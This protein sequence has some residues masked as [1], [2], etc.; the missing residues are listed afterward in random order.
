MR[1]LPILRR[2]DSNV[3]LTLN[4]ETDTRTAMVR[5][6]CEYLE[7]MEFSYFGERV[8]RFKKVFE[9]WSEFEENAEYP[10]AFV[11]EQVEGE[12]DNEGKLTPSVEL[13]DMDSPHGLYLVCY[14][15]YTQSL[16]IQLWATDPV[17]RMALVAMIENHLNPVEWKTGVSVVLPHYFNAVCT[18]ELRYCKYE[19]SKEQSMQ[20]YR[21]ASIG[22]DARVPLLRLGGYPTARILSDV[23]VD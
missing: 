2:E 21:V 5:G 20:R 17:E 7:D 1:T 18:F 9:S 6:L 23:T 8:F 22:I 10:S 12:Y 4:Q 14:G 13:R 19:E 16:A 15:E 3:E 11:Y